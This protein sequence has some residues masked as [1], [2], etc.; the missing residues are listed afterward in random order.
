MNYNDVQIG[1]RVVAQIPLDQ[2]TYFV[3]EDTLKDLG[4][5]DSLAF[6]YYKGMTV[7][8][9]LE[10]SRYEWT[11]STTG[12]LPT[13]FTYPSN[14]IVNGVDYSNKQYNF[15]F[16]TARGDTGPQGPVG[17]AGPVGPI[18]PLGLTGP[19]G[20]QGIPGSIGPTGATG[21]QGSPGLTGATG[22]AGPATPNLQKTVITSAGLSSYSLTDADNGYVI[23]VDTTY[24]DISIV[25]G[26]IT[27][28]N[29]CVGFI[30]EGT[31]DITFTG[32]TNPV[33]LK[34]KGAGF[35]TFIERKLATSNYYL[36][37]NTKA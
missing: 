13:S 21:P 2:K 8:C 20:P 33:G 24:S 15:V 30:H 32:A 35:Q 37:G 3:S 9:V 10:K 14:L 17:P 31:H 18:G 29:F 34:S 19:Q 4:P 23:F 26:A 6:T 16:T 25:I 22:P 27:L 7:Y 1:L 5:E 28:S 12:L 11:E 36:L